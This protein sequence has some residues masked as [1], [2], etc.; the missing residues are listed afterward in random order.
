MTQLPH[1]PIEQIPTTSP[2]AY[3]FRITCRVDDDASE[4]LAKFML[5]A[6]D[7]HD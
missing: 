3:A 4:A 6:F 1:D 7:K 2:T 5:K